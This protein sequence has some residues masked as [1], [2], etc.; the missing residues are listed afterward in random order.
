MEEKKSQEKAL[1]NRR[2]ERKDIINSLESELSSYDNHPGDSA[3]ELYMIEQEQ[4]YEAQI[5]EKI[6]SINTSLEDIENGTYGICH[7]CNKKI[8]E[9]RLELIPYAKTCLD[10]S[11]EE[12]FDSEIE[13]NH[14]KYESLNYDKPN[15]DNPGYDR[16]D[17][18]QDIMQDNIVD[19]DPSY[20]TGDNTGF[21]DKENAT[22]SDTV[23]DVENIAEDYYEDTLE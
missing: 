10:C 1:K 9:E 3:T 19:K 17:I 12:K 11:E 13:A 4:A 8:R 5:K 20:S 15:A 21:A 16:E 23:E 22:D 6:K 14:K 18:S 2:E 7:N